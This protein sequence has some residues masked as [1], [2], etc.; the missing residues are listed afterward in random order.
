VG[1][2][3][4]STRRIACGTQWFRLKT[5]I[6]RGSENSNDKICNS[7]NGSKTA[8]AKQRQQQRQSVDADCSESSNSEIPSI[9]HLQQQQ[10][11]SIRNGT[12]KFDQSA[13]IVAANC[14]DADQE[15]R[16]NDERFP[17]V[18]LLTSDFRLSADPTSIAP[19]LQ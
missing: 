5:L 17:L 14:S 3:P 12:E 2:T 18:G 9:N 11:S 8:A 4:P 16:S 19:L 6:A 10:N 15:H 7:G 1:G 13:L